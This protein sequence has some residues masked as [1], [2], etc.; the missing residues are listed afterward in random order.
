MCFLYVAYATHKFDIRDAYI[1]RI[2]RIFLSNTPGAEQ[3]LINNHIN[4]KVIICR[5]RRNRK[6]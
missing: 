5:D 4:T 1:R 3:L 6:D 2:H